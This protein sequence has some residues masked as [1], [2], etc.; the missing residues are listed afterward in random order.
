M[1]WGGWV[2]QDIAGWVTVGHPQVAEQASEPAPEPAEPATAPPAP[3]YAPPP[4]DSPLPDSANH[5]E[6]VPITCQGKHGYYPVA[7]VV[8]GPGNSMLEAG[9]RS[10][11]VSNVQEVVK[12][13]EY[14]VTGPTQYGT[15]TAT[16]SNRTSYITYRDRKGQVVTDYCR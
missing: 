12:G 13:I 2:E 11:A 15:Y 5:V 14:V 8:Y 4:V 7:W 6:R 16:F 3:T 10:W 1:R 9:K